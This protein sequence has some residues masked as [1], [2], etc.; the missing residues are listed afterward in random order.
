MVYKY[1]VKVQ[2][3]NEEFQKKKTKK[4]DGSSS[5]AKVLTF[6]NLKK[7]LAARFKI[8]PVVAVG[9]NDEVQL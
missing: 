1:Y 5:K 7:N 8:E 3:T 4:K 9:C 2:E 6:V